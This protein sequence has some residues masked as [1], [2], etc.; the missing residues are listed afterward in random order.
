VNAADLKPRRSDSSVDPHRDA[1]ALLLAMS[2]DDFKRGSESMAMILRPYD[3]DLCADWLIVG[4]L[5]LALEK[6]QST[7][8]FRQW[9]QEQ[10]LAAALDETT[11][12]YAEYEDD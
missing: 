9:V 1:Y 6:R 3:T 10:A 8:A 5:Q 12:P 4:L 11:D 7:K 2:D